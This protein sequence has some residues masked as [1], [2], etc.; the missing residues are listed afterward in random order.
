MYYLNPKG[1]HSTW[2]ALVNGKP[3]RKIDYLILSAMDYKDWRG[4]LWNF[5]NAETK[6]KKYNVLNQ[7]S[8]F[9]LIQYEY[10]VDKIIMIYYYYYQTLVHWFIHHLCN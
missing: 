4:H 1:F 3:M 10:F 9:S 8:P 6:L 5:V 2:T 7:H